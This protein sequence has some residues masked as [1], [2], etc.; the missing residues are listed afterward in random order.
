MLN[1]FVK[2][3]VTR[4]SAV[5][6]KKNCHMSFLKVFKKLSVILIENPFKLVEVVLMLDELSYHLQKVLK[7]L[8]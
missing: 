3:N 8:V 2:I 6:M 1:Y 7:L 5:I 4:N